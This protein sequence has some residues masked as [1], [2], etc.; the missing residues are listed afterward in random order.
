MAVA[1]DRSSVI[2]GN[3]HHGIVYCIEK[4]CF[5]NGWKAFLRNRPSAAS[6]TAEK[7]G[8]ASYPDE[9]CMRHG[10]FSVFCFQC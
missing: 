4:H 5:A 10:H 3:S 8:A 6:I 2:E 1:V 9:S 7:V